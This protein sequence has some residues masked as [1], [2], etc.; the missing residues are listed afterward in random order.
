[1]PVL[2]FAKGTTA[3]HYQA[4]VV[5]IEDGRPIHGID[6]ARL[7]EHTLFIKGTDAIVAAVLD[8]KRHPP[9]FYPKDGVTMLPGGTDWSCSPLFPYAG[10][11]IRLDDR[12]FTE[13]ALGEV[14]HCAIDFRVA[15][16]SSQSTSKMARALRDMARDDMLDKFPFLV[17]SLTL[18]LTSETIKLLS[19]KAAARM[20]RKKNGLD[21]ARKRRVIDFA[22][23]NLDKLISLS[24]MAAVANLSPYHFS[25]SFKLSTGM[26][27]AKFML[28]RRTERAKRLLREGRA[29]L[30]E[31][32]LACGFASQSHFSTAFKQVVGMT[33]GQFRRSTWALAVTCLAQLTEPIAALAMKL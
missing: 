14:E 32:A 25:R 21:P 5:Q 3:D 18:A 31:I 23:A 22:E 1:M 26:P 7:P 6:R 17:E 4:S 28:M 12:M 33:P 2:Q 16:V 20:E 30:A 9:M 27:P 11:L 10:T 15:D 8:G 24:D 29:G 13:A 19:P